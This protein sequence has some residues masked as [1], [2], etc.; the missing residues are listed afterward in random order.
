MQ[1]YAELIWD[2]ILAFLGTDL[3]TCSDVPTEG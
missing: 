3:P 1:Y 2:Q